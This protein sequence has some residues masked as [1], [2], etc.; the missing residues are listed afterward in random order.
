MTIG[1]IVNA[2]FFFCMRV[3]AIVRPRSVVSFVPSEPETIDACNEVRAVCGGFGVAVSLRQIFTAKNEAIKLGATLAVAAS[4]FGMAI[5]RVSS[6]FLER[7]GKWPMVFIFT[8]S[9]WKGLLLW[10]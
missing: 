2:V 7:P 10:A 1:I 5:G 3:S 8:E 6:L 9:G 4:L